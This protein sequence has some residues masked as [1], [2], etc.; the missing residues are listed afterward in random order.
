MPVRSTS[1]ASASGA[2]L[3]IAKPSGVQVDDRLVIAL[4]QWNEAGVAALPTGWLE[5]SSI[6]GAMFRT[7]WR[8]V[9]GAEGSTFTFTGAS[10]T[11]EMIGVIFA[12]TGI[13][14]ASSY[15]FFENGASIPSSSTPAAIEHPDL[16]AFMSQTDEM[17]GVFAGYAE[18]TQTPTA[19]APLTHL[20]SKQ[21]ANAIV[22]MA[23]AEQAVGFPLPTGAAYE[24]AISPGGTSGGITN[25]V[26]RVVP[27]DPD[28]PALTPASW[29]VGAV[30]F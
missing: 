13:S 23:F 26:K 14:T 10:G 24:T 6:N 2:S 12:L 22:T 30:R 3:T 1:T 15:G 19:V 7:A 18:G 20:L 4:L 29:T 8:K 25:W 21:G 16:A 5:A 11:A 17:S 28:P 27:L 9:T